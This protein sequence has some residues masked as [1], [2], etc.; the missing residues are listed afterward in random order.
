ML[1]AAERNDEQEYT[2]GSH[3]TR[4]MDADL[5]PVHARLDEWSREARGA[6]AV[7]ALPRESYYHKWS[8]L[9]IAPN[10][11]HWPPMSERA[12]NVDRA[13]RKLGEIDRSVIWRFYLAWRPVDIWKGLHGIKDENN[14]GRVLKRARYRVHGHLMAIE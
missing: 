3:C 7:L 6:F 4:R 14:F 11:G 8:L 5:Q 2:R 9:G 13:V 10:P 1:M 12:A